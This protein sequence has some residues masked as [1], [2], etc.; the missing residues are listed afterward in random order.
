MLFGQVPREDK[1]ATP[2]TTAATPAATAA[3]VFSFTGFTAPAEHAA[4]PAAEGDAE[5]TE[6]TDDK[7]DAEEAEKEVNVHFEPVLKLDEVDV[8]D[9]EEDEEAVFKIRAKLFRFDKEAREWKERGLGDVRLMQHNATKKIRLLMRREKT[10]KVCANHLVHPNMKLEPN[11]G[12]DRSWVWS[13]LADYSEMP[14]TK[15]VFAIRFGNPENAQKFKDEFI[16]A[17]K[18]NEGILQSEKKEEN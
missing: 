7:K 1:E 17:Q 4:A 9:G 12:S 6:H 3:P 2:A 16:A 14:P 11:S 10:L 5:H 18:V 13:C 15:E 8:Q